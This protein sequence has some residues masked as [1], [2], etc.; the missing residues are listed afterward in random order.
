MC[1]VAL[2]PDMTQLINLLHLKSGREALIHN[3]HLV[4]MFFQLMKAYDT[5]LKYGVM[6]DLNGF[7]LRGC[8]P[9]FINNFLKDRSFKVRVGTIFSDSHPQG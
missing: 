1:N 5:T 8:F 2:V 4:S 7:Q 3:Q 6:K 9:N